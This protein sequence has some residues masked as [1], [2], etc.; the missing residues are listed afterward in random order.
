MATPRVLRGDLKDLFFWES[1]TSFNQLC[2]PDSLVG[3]SAAL[4]AVRKGR[5]L[6]RGLAVVVAVTKAPPLGVD[7]EDSRA[8]VDVSRGA[9]VLLDLG[10][11][12]RLP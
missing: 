3:S 6:A 8:D 9:A 10:T 1:P 5:T 11:L 4:I 7:G 12:E 2:I